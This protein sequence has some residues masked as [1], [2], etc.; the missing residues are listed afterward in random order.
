MPRAQDRPGTQNPGRRGG[1]CGIPGERGAGQGSPRR[2][3][4]H[5][6][7]APPRR[8]G[9]RGGWKEHMPPATPRSLP[10]CVWGLGESGAGVPSHRPCWP[11]PL[12]CGHYLLWAAGLG[13]AG[14]RSDTCRGLLATSAW[15]TGSVQVGAWPAVGLSSPRAL[16]ATAQCV[17]LQRLVLKGDLHAAED[18]AELGPGLGTTC[19]PSPQACR[20]R[21]TGLLGAAC[22][23]G[24]SLLRQHLGAASGLGRQGPRALPAPAPPAHP[25]ALR[26]PRS[27]R[28]PRPGC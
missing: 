21:L 27:W 25:S 16:A 24:G 23:H 12:P 2:E 15:L 7:P 9:D 5:T 6:S 13:R 1:D 20:Q 28:C 18:A 14:S 10:A 19:T 26:A 4:T 11:W 3:R 8:S 17:Q 22:G